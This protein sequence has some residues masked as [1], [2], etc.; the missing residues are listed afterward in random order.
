[1]DSNIDKVREALETLCEALELALARLGVCGQG[2]GADHKADADSIGGTNA[3]TM[4]RAALSTLS[5]IDPEAIRRGCADASDR[6]FGGWSAYPGA[7]QAEN[8]AA[9]ANAENGKPE[10]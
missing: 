3:L 9:I 8:R 5:S 6:V 7:K 2:D 1:M 10:C 4:G